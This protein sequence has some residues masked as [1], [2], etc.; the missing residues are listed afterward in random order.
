L[1]AL[2]RA[3]ATAALV[4]ESLMRAEDPEAAVRALAEAPCPP[5]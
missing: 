4:G 5:G 3:G 2:A 1:A